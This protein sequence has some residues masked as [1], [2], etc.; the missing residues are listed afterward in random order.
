MEDQLSHQDEKGYREECK[1]CNGRESA[2]HHPDQ[3]WQSSQEKIGGDHIDNKKGEGNRQVGEKQ[4]DHASKEQ[5]DDQPPFHRLPPTPRDKLAPGYSEKLDGQEDAAYGDDDEHSGFRNS[6]CPHVGY[7]V[8]QTVAQMDDPEI[9]EQST[10]QPADDGHDTIQSILGFLIEMNVDDIRRDM[11][12]FSQ[13]PGGSE[14]NDPQQ[15]IFR[16]RD[17]PYRG[18]IKQESHE[19]GVTDS[20]RYKHEYDGRATCHHV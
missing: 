11:P 16:H 10:G 7:P 4:E 13:K 18:L 5:T 12:C 3:A 19:D 17:D 20:S 2:C 9:D 15:G 8:Y 6:D 1:S 14:E